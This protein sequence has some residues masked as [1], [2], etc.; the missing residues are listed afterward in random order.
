MQRDVPVCSDPP[1]NPFKSTKP[2]IRISATASIIPDPQMPVTPVVAIA[3]SNPCSVDQ[4]SDPMTLNRGSLVV[5]SISMR[6]I[7]PGAARWPLEICAPSKAGPVGDEQASTWLVSPSRI[8]ALVPTST[9]NVSSVWLAGSSDSAT[10]AAS[11]PTW[12]A[13]QGRMKTRAAAFIA[14]R[15]KSPASNDR[16]FDVAKA[17]GAWPSSTGSIPNNR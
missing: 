14:V 2:A 7:A 9:I 10:A 8:S 6:S 3:A 11:A 13:I 17:K 15:S 1:I 12:P 16:D 5:G 4:R